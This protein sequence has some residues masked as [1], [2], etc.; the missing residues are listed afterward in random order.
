MSEN[1]MEKVKLLRLKVGA[2]ML[3]CKKAL[4]ES[5]YDL[6]EAILY[7]RKK[8]LIDIL[9]KSSKQA[10]QGVISACVSE[11]K[12]TAVI[13]E[14]NC[15]TDFVA[16]S[17]DFIAYVLKI[18][19]YFLS[20]TEFGQFFDMCDKNI[21]VNDKFKNLHIDLVSRCKENI[22]IRRVKRIHTDHGF[23]FAYTHGGD[24][25]YGNIGS[26][27]CVDNILGYED[28]VKDVAIQVVAMK[29]K[30]LNV[31]TI[32]SYLIEQEK[33]LYLEK[34][35]TQNSA[36]KDILDKIVDGQLKKFYKDVV[37]LEQ[38]FVKDVKTNVKA[39]ID[40][41]FKVLDFVRFEVGES[42]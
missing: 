25:N 15:E 29:P 5:N 30:Y 9:Q 42:I 28:L 16:R 33:S 6:D 37:L 1:L 14:V 22:L 8:G 40:G 11:N 13:L 38:N 34:F 35:A 2:G 4:Q 12:R 10:G 32:P 27:V 31:D 18:S 7:L 21:T 39:C 20:T 26:L 17:D 36:S 23:L 19:E 41:K 24:L 3:D